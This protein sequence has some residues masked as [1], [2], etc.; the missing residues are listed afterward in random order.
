MQPTQK[1]SARAAVTETGTK[2]R[3]NLQLP[4]REAVRTRSAHV[5]FPAASCWLRR[6]LFSKVLLGVIVNRDP[7]SIRLFDRVSSMSLPEAPGLPS[8]KQTEKESR[9]GYYPN[10]AVL[11]SFL[12]LVLGLNSKEIRQRQ[13]QLQPNWN[14]EHVDICLSMIFY[15]KG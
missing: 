9:E 13:I 14:L 15:L 8:Q 7:G 3:Q 6:H 1:L 5:C 10:F 2:F 11:P 12:H 4:S